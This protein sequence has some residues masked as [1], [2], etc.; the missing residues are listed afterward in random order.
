MQ[1]SQ[2]IEACDYIDEAVWKE[3]IKT[4]NPSV[5]KAAARDYVACQAEKI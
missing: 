4:L 5:V 3:L 1:R 2:S